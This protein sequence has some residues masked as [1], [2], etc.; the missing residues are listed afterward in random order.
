MGGELAALNQPPRIL[1]HAMKDPD[2]AH[3]DRVQV[4]KGWIED[5]ESFERVY[6]V[7]WS[8]DRA[9]DERGRI[10]NVRDTVDRK[11]A[12]YSNEYGAVSLSVIWIDP[13][14]DAE[15]AAFYYVRALEI[16]TPRH[17]LLDVVALGLDPKFSGESYSIQERAYTSPVFYTP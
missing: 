10:E 9:V 4:I 2:S 17:S 15:Q 7:A 8:G 11:T 16:P 6:D 12:R 3:L 14:F 13:D 1:V 5:G